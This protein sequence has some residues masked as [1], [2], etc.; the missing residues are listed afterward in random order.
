MGDMRQCLKVVVGGRD[1]VI[2][3]QLVLGMWWE[4]GCWNTVEVSKH[5]GS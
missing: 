2:I 1:C 3:V 4:E 5:A